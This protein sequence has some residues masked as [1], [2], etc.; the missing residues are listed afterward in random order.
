MRRVG[1]LVTESGSQAAFADRRCMGVA[2]APPLRRVGLGQPMVNS[3]RAPL[4]QAS[5]T[6]W[7]VEVTASATCFQSDPDRMAANDRDGVICRL[8]CPLP[9]PWELEAATR[10]Y[11]RLVSGAQ[12]RGVYFPFGSAATR[13]AEEQ[14]P[15]DSAP[16]MS[17]IGRRHAPSTA[18]PAGGGDAAYASQR[19]Q[20]VRHRGSNAGGDQQQP[21]HSWLRRCDPF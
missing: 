20:G 7:D 19:L 9:G 15:F 14:Q 3:E 18:A 16:T 12:S 5:G 4:L 21:L 2:V 11:E 13:R 6:G 1:L 10:R 8:V 17:D